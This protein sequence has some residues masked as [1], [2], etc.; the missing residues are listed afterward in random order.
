MVDN[1]KC[2]HQG[3]KKRRFAFVLN[4]QHVVERLRYI[5]KRLDEIVQSGYYC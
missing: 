2:K 1:Q 3:P 4:P 5:N